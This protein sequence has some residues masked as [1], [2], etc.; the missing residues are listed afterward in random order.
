MFEKSLR[1]QHKR[2]DV[3][4][5]YA[6]DS[7]LNKMK[8]GFVQFKAVFYEGMNPTTTLELSVPL[9]TSGALNSTGVHV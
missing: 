8:C 6:E 3:Q 9:C 7:V 2:L 5:V 4:R 1:K